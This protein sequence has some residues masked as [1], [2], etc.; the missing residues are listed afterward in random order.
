[1]ATALLRIVPFLFCFWISWLNAGA[2]V[3][4]DVFEAFT[5][6][7][8][9]QIQMD[10]RTFVEADTCTQ[11]FYK[12]Q[13]RKPPRPKAQGTALEPAQWSRQRILETPEC[14]TR[15]P[16]G[17]EAAREAFSRT[18][19]SLSL[20]LTFYEF[21]LVGD[22]NVDGHYSVIELRDMLES[23]GLLFDAVLA[24]AVHLAALNAQFDAVRKAGS[25]DVLM[26][27]I[28]TLYD[29]GYRLTSRDRAALDQVTG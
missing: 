10:K 3:P 26:T 27:S 17:L 20:S 14:R 24:P 29:K 25:P 1:M 22:R 21:A 18:Q 2:A 9:Q 5:A 23:F 6:H 13:Y 4:D 28:G 8:Q 19:S 16:G 12:Q 11:W 7:I 15:N